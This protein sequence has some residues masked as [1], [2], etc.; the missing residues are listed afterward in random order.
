MS[1]SY[2]QGLTLD[3]INNKKG[4]SKS[5]CRWATRKEQMNN[6]SLN[7]KRIVYNG[8]S[9]NSYELSLLT[10]VERRTLEER[11][12]RGVPVD[13]AVVN[14]KHIVKKIHKPNKR[15]VFILYKG[16]KYMQYQ[17]QEKLGIERHTLRRRITKGKINATYITS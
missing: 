11:I 8:V 6:Y 12:N 7:R 3:R 2:S 9:Y 13:L 10:G 4:Y 14:R 17:L 15:S 1:P 16:K 5:N